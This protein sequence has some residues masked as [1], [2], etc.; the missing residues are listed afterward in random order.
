[1]EK[2]QLTVEQELSFQK[3]LKQEKKHSA[4]IVSS[5]GAVLFL[6]LALINYLALPVDE[7]TKVLPTTL[8]TLLVLG[9]FFSLTYR[10]CFYKHY[11][12]IGMTTFLTVGLAICFMIAQSTPARYTHNVYFLTLLLLIVTTF[13]WSYMPRRLSILVTAVLIATFTSIKIVMHQAL[14]DEPLIL[15]VSVFFL[16]ASASIVAMAQVLRDKY[17][18]KTFLLQE[19]LQINFE[20][21]AEEAKRQKELA[22]KD[23]LTG[24]PNR[25]YITKTLDKAVQK[26]QRENLYLVIMFLDLNG[27]KAV[28]DNYGHDAGDEIL[29]VISARLKSCIREEDHLARIGG[30]EFL[31]GLLVKKSETDIPDKIRRKIRTTIIEP[32]TFK[33][34]HL[35]VGTSIGTSTFPKDGESIEALIKLADD[36]MYV[37]KLSIKSKQKR[38]EPKLTTAV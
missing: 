21:K 1:M 7:F 13:S 38:L 4:R 37:D 34:H 17:I 6:C 35:K 2:I 14:S 26:A 33:E 22:N 10:Y 28:N 5:L 11:S 31:I 3:S 36:N 18:Y 24:L 32:V 15:V 25:R 16:I 29:T 12:L 19:Q 27:F 30:D 23:A 8:V 9:V 20:E